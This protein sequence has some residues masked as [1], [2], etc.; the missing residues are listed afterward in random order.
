M[1]L[2]S[3]APSALPPG[4]H[5]VEG[6]PD[7]TVAYGERLEPFIAGRDKACQRVK[8]WRLPQSRHG[9]TVHEPE[10]ATVAARVVAGHVVAVERHKGT[11][12][13]YTVQWEDGLKEAD[14]SMRLLREMLMVRPT[15]VGI[16][17]PLDD[18][19]VHFMRRA[20]RVIG[21][22]LDRLRTAVRVREMA[23]VTKDGTASAGD[24]YRVAMAAMIDC[25]MLCK[26]A[27][28]WELRADGLI[29]V[30]A[31]QDHANPFRLLRAPRRLLEIPG[32]HRYKFWDLIEAKRSFEMPFA[33]EIVIAPFDDTS[34]GKSVGD[35]ALGPAAGTVFALVATRVAG[36]RWAR[37]ASFLEEMT[38]EVHTAL[39]CI[40]GREARAEE[41]RQAVERV[42]IACS[43]SHT[44]EPEGQLERLALREIEHCLP[45]CDA[46]VGELRARAD[47]L[48]YVAATPKSQMRGRV[49]TRAQGGVSF[50]CIPPAI[51]PSV[52]V[53]DP[54]KPLPPPPLSKGLRVEVRYG[55]IYYPALISAD[56]GHM[57]YDV[58]Y[59]S[60]HPTRNVIEKEAGVPAGRIRLIPAALPKPFRW[61]TTTAASA[62][63]GATGGVAADRTDAHADALAGTRSPAR[64]PG[65]PPRRA[66]PDARRARR[67]ARRR[68]LARQPPT[69]SPTTRT[70]SWLTM[71]PLR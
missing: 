37:D 62:T 68:A 61:P 56:R 67:R 10:N 48:E 43:G 63:I 41:R 53:R 13:L 65:R 70:T 35:V 51:A 71:R 12:P 69:R 46:Y 16:G 54:A 52:T 55:R 38:S 47:V 66:R 21:D 25:V 5:E 33:T 58:I 60:R 45:G 8:I 1:P 50:D 29:D 18:S 23:A 11:G 31:R 32:K 9:S 6:D 14:I 44:H 2:L 17:T 28:V 24:V 20:A 7:A 40:R 34:A 49:L 59:E 19:A 4:D 3:G 64:P 27:E 39:A 30:I 42:R 15:R 26:V 57:T 22:H 36:T